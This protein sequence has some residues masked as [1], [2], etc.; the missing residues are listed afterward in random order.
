MGPLCL[1]CL[2]AYFRAQIRER[3]SIDGRFYADLIH[4]ICCCPCVATQE[5]KHLDF[6]CMLAEEERVVQEQEAERKRMKELQLEAQIKQQNEEKSVAQLKLG[7]STDVHKVAAN[8]ATR[9]MTMMRG[10]S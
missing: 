1:P 5:A 6:M 4:W 9:Q 10:N 7:K 2:G 3:F 8:P